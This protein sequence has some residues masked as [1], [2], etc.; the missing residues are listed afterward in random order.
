MENEIDSSKNEIPSYLVDAKRNAIR[1]C[2]LLYRGRN[3]PLIQSLMPF[4]WDCGDGWNYKIARLSYKLEAMNLLMY[5]KYGIYI[6]AE[7]V[8]E[9]YGTL[10]FYYGI[11]N[12]RLESRISKLLL[13]LHNLIFNNVDFKY[14]T[15]IDAPESICEEWEEI[16][17]KDFNDKIIPKHVAND[18]G[19]K[20]RRDGIKFYRN[21]CVYHPSK[22]HKEP[23][24][25]RL[26]HWVDDKLIYLNGYLDCCFGR[27]PSP[28]E[29][30]ITE[31]MDGYAEDCVEE[32][33]KHCYNTCEE[34]G[35]QIGDCGD[36]RCETT[37]WIRYLCPQC[38]KKRGCNYINGKGDLCSTDG[39]VI[40]TASTRRRRMEKGIKKTNE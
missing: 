15:V 18:F 21:S 5:P 4:G 34:C 27:N 23:T 35:Y 12:D 3:K 20:F 13:Y 7:Q 24:R 9:K 26:L 39:K 19:W 32:A 1:D 29:Q 17:E 40:E 37:G 33:E 22:Q 14:K 16:T 8:K 30:V 31:F 11:R 38:A 6:E 25:M 10:R 2:R 28:E 36:E